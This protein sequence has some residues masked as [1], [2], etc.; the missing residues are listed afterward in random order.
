MFNTV[1]HR[2]L[3]CGGLLRNV[4]IPL[5]RYGGI[6]G[7]VLKVTIKYTANFVANFLVSYSGIRYVTKWVDYSRFTRG[8]DC[9]ERDKVSCFVT[10][11]N[12]IV[13]S[14]STFVSKGRFW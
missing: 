13:K 3:H 9:K 2:L 11:N 8:S 14:S 6:Y 12:N 7:E 1:L 10:K 5:F 4:K